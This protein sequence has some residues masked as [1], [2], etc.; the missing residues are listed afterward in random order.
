[1]KTKTLKIF[2]N[3]AKDKLLHFFYGSIISFISILF[4]GIQGLWITVVIAAAKEIVYDGLMKKGNV[5]IYDFIFTC[6]PCFMYLII[7]Q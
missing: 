1:M 2:G 7:L 5:D 6:I 3:I 4:F